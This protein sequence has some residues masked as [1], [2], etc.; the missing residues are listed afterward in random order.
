MSDLN[1]IN[2]YFTEEKISAIVMI[3]L[4]SISLV[5]AIFFL[6]LIKYSFFKGMAFPLLL[7]GIIQITVGIT[8]VLKT[9]GDI[10]RVEY[11]MN[12]EP[13]KLRSEEFPRMEKVQQNFI[14]YKC[15]EIAL[16][17]LG[18]ILIV[19][20]Y[21]SSQTFWKGLGVG[22]LLQAGLIFTLDLIAEKRAET[23]VNF[24]L[25]AIS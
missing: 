13:D 1:F 8:I 25:K 21:N 9:P 19:G 6:L 17:L 23:Y 18:V 7:I 20:F 22:L 24:L 5:L 12:N 15:I 10:I 14:I 11:H 2:T 4:G 3:I 16:I